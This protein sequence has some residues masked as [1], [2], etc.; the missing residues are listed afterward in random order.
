MKTNRRVSKHPLTNSLAAIAAASL[1]GVPALAFGA[2]NQLLDGPMWNYPAQ[3][4]SK[5]PQPTR[6][7][8]LQQLLQ[9]KRRGNY[10]I[11]AE[12]G[13]TAYQADPSAFP[14]HPRRPGKTRAQ[15]LQALKKAERSG[16]YVIDGETGQKADQSRVVG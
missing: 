5:A 14:A 15:V 7:E 12:T 13:Q 3:S 8:V 1:L 16:N 6:A 11:D 10:V 2:T 9:A 4:A